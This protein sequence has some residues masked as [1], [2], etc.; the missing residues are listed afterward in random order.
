MS[1]DKMTI[2]DAFI[3]L[4]AAIKD[5]EDPELSLE[6]SFARYNEGL[7]LVKYCN[8]SIDKIEQQ[9]TVL[10]EDND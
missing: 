4:E 2:E 1:T 8:D 7:Q 5:I 10:E 6:E 3:K 9:L